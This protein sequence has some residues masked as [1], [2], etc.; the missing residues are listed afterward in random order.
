MYIVL[1]MFDNPT[2]VTNEDGDVLYFD[3]LDEAQSEADDCQDGK[4]VEC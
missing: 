3:T 4:V 2:V 1:E